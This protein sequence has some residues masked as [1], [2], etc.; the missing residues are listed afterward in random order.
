M[1]KHQK[2]PK[3]WGVSLVGYNEKLYFYGNE[4]DNSAVHHSFYE[5]DL[6]KIDFQKRVDEKIRAKHMFKSG[7]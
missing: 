7:I 1:P 5:Y 2:L 4:D 3:M 6:G